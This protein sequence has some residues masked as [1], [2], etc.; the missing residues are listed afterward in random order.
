[1]ALYGISVHFFSSLTGGSG[2]QCCYRNDALVV[3]PPGG[4]TVDFVSPDVDFI[5]H[6]VE[7]V[8]PYLLCCKA[9]ILSN[10]AEYYRHRP[11]DDG[12]PPPP[13]PPPPGISYIKIAVQL[14][15]W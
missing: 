10:C 1:M 2:Q 12:Y 5:G 15:L 7:D 4:G 8:V 14:V 13:P 3:G 11:S 9:G 6:F